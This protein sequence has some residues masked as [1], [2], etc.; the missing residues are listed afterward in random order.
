VFQAQFRG[1]KGNGVD[2]FKNP[3]T[4]PIITPAEYK[5]GDVI[6]PFEKARQ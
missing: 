1:I 3:E 2:Q 4:L 6:Y 5:S